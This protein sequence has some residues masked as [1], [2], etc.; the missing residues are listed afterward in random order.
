MELYGTEGGF[1]YI[2]IASQTLKGFSIAYI[3]FIYCIILG[4]EKHMSWA[5]CH[6]VEN[7]HSH[8]LNLPRLL[9]YCT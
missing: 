3:L 8:F 9:S 7:A 6:G 2:S 5:Q 4:V 1:W